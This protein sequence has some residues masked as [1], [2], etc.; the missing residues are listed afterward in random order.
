LPVMAILFLIAES[1]SFAISFAAPFVSFTLIRLSRKK[2]MQS[3]Y[4]LRASTSAW[5]LRMFTVPQSLHWY[6][7]LPAFPPQKNEDWAIVD[8]R[9]LS[10]PLRF[11]AFKFMEQFSRNLLRTSCYWGL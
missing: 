8:H 1:P 4:S 2:A 3:V 5:S 6:Y 11:S 9:A 7:F 10:E